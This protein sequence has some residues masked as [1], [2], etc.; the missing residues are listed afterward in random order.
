ML[1][2]TTENP[3]VPGLYWHRAQGIDPV[4][5]RL[6]ETGC[7]ETLNYERITALHEALVLWPK[8]EWAGPLEPPP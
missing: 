7:V 8:S 2:W 6:T 1:T 5:V 3:M 4:V